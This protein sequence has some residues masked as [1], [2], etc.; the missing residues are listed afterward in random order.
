MPEKTKVYPSNNVCIFCSIANGKVPSKKVY[1]DDDSIAFLDIYP[2]SKGM[3]IVAPKEHFDEMHDNLMGALKSFQTAEVVAR[4]LKE[5]L[6]AKFVEMGI[7]YSDDVPHFHIKLYPVYTNE[8]PLF[9]KEAL[10]M[11][12][13]ELDELAKRIG[14]VKVEPNEAYQEREKEEVER[15]YTEEE[16]RFIRNSLDEA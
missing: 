10:D 4:M 14:A 9:E 13:P 16:E 5:A 12:E 3:T 11:N 2:R 1:E 7:M 8:R 6:G 15:K